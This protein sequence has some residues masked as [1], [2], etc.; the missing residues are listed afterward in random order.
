M[1]LRPV[2]ALMAK[3]AGMVDSPLLTGIA[4]DAELQKR[5][6]RYATRDNIDAL[7][8]D[9]KARAVIVVQDAFTTYFET[10]LVLDALTLLQALGFTPLL[11]PYYANGTALHVHGFLKA[12]ARTAERNSAM[13][14][15]LAKT[16]LPL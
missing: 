5:G 16:G 2:Q 9:E 13:L 12:F 15:T 4:L 7:N 3:V 14:T 1:R 10:Q 6:I 11:A 8:T